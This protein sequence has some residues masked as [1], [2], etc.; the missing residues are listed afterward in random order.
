[1]CKQGQLP[2]VITKGQQQFI[3]PFGNSP[4][5]IIRYMQPCSTT[6]AVQMS[7]ATNM[8]WPVRDKEQRGRDDVG[9]G[10]FFYCLSLLG[11]NLSAA[12]TVRVGSI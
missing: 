12:T 11:N 5:S 8:T 1:M 6:P 10:G 4:Q 3:V 9:L 2:C 7:L